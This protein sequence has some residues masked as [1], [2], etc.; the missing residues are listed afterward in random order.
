MATPAGAGDR[1]T[2]LEAAPQD[3]K[4]GGSSPAGLSYLSITRPTVPHLSTVA[5][6]SHVCTQGRVFRES[7]AMLGPVYSVSAAERHL[8]NPRLAF[9]E[10][11]LVGK[12]EITP[13]PP[14]ASVTRSQS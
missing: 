6:C 11:P 9:L 13:L 4:A 8:H 3:G 7:S 10:W 12:G 2:H 14:Q 5:T 1:R